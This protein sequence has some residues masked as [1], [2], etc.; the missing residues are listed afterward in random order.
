MFVFF[1][2]PGHLEPILYIITNKEN[3]SERTIWFQP[4]VYDTAVLCV[5]FLLKFYRIRRQWH[6]LIYNFNKSGV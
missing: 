5:C 6:N 1:I 2:R 3:I 4:T